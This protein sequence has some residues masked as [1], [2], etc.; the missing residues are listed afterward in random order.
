MEVKIHK[1]IYG[2][3]LENK[4]TVFLSVQ[5]APSLEDAFIQAKFEFE[6]INP[7]QTINGNP[8]NGA[9]IWLFTVK[10]VDELIRETR[11]IS[12]IQGADKIKIDEWKKVAKNFETPPVKKINKKPKIEDIKSK[13]NPEEEKRVLKNLLM[14]KIIDNKDKKAFE[15]NIGIFTDHERSYIMERLS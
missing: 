14:K 2:V 6:R 13:Q 10:T 5:L 9:K 12:E 15:E 7:T 4:E 8:M 11:A 1:K 3:I